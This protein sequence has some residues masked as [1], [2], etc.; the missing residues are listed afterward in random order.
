[1]YQPAPNPFQ[2]FYFKSVNDSKAIGYE[3]FH[4]FT[5]LCFHDSQMETTFLQNYYSAPN[6]QKLL[7]H[8]LTI[9]AFIYL[10]STV[11]VAPKWALR[12]TAR[13]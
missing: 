1:L 8:Q 13:I 3:N 7:K 11:E 4:V 9:F 12:N 2:E 6:L 5:M 10:I